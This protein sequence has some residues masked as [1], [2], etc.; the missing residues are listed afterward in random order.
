MKLSY[1]KFVTTHNK[2]QRRYLDEI[3]SYF[4]FDKFCLSVSIIAFCYFLINYFFK[5]SFIFLDI[6]RLI[7]LITGVAFSIIYRI[8]Y[9][10]SSKLRTRL[11]IEIAKDSEYYF[12]TTYN[13]SVIK[14]DKAFLPLERQNA[15]L[16]FD[17]LFSNGLGTIHLNKKQSERFIVIIDNQKY[18]IVPE[19]FESEVLI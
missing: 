4:D 8:K 1:F 10:L 3:A 5:N 2:I 16:F 17:L 15:D 9:F 13:K 18:Y 11:I 19:L 14:L 12:L 7:G 6:P